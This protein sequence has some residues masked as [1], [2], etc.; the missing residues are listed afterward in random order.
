MNKERVEVIELL[1]KVLITGIFYGEDI[2][3]EKREEMV[4]LIK[5]AI[6][7]IEGGGYGIQK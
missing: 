2:P 5:E 7:I 4:E 1:T 3:F 6:N